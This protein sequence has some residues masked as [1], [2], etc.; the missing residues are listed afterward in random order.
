[1]SETLVYWE[2][3]LRPLAEARVSVRDRSFRYGEAVFETL[4]A[5]GIRVFRLPAHLERLRRSAAAMGWQLPWGDGALDDI[6]TR[7]L[8][9]NRLGE[10]RVRIQATRGAGGPERID[11]PPQLLIE[12]EPLQ[13]V[14]EAQRREGVVLSVAGHPRAS[15]GA[16]VGAKTASYLENLLARRGARQVGAHDALLL[17]ER[18]E[19][20][21]ATSANL[22]VWRGGRLRTPALECGV[23]AGITRAVVLELAEAMGAPGLPE[24]LRLEDVLAS[25]EAFLT[26]T[27]I[28]LLPVSCVGGEKVGDGRPGP[29]TRDLAGR[30]DRALSHE[31][32]DAER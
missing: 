9:A 19:V 23:L 8:E 7:T 16:L 20:C 14:P 5:R 17:N 29:W 21:E 31:L 28:G 15:R 27:S 26:S 18:D 2:D 13:P 3:A 22:F 25:D 6:L 24:R 12:A 10:A 32:G 4:R 11:G 30:Y 1:M